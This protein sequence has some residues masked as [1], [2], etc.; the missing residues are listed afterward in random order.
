[1]NSSPPACSLLDSCGKLKLSERATFFSWTTAIYAR[2]A[3]S[4]SNESLRPEISSSIS[5]AME[6]HICSVED[7]S[8]FELGKTMIRGDP[9]R[10]QM[11]NS[12]ILDVRRIDN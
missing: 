10:L 9:N 7:V 11:I 3:V 2:S 4:P 6:R 8:T 5:C 1:M 12:L